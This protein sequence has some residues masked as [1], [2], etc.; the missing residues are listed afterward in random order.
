MTYL[1]DKCLPYEGR[2][3]PGIFHRVTQAVWWTM[4]RRGFNGLVVYLD[5]FI[6]IA[7]TREECQL[8]FDTLMQLLKD[9]GF[10]IS[11]AKFVLP[12]QLLVFLG[13]QIDTNALVLPL[14]KDKLNK[15][16]AIVQ[17]FVSRKRASKHQLQTLA[18]KLNWACTVVYG[19]WTFL[20]SNEHAVLTW[21][22]IIAQ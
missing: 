15:T 18:G 2:S 11:I 4:H 19:G 13:I 1:I 3:A 9:L 8:A 7:P 20:Q 21:C 12:C 14:P 10:Q 5:D 22:T 6:I 17:S 16:K